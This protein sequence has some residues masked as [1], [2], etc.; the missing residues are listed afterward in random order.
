M[1]AQIATEPFDSPEHAF[2]I[3]WDGVR[4]I[5]LVEPGQLRL[6][7]RRFSEMR[8]QYP[9]LAGLSELPAGTVVDGEII[10]LD[11]GRSSFQKLAQRIHLNDPARIAMASRRLPT[12]FV[13]FDL[14]YSAGVSVMDQSLR[15]RRVLLTAL[16]GE[17]KDPHVVAADFVEG[18]GLAYFEAAK[19]AGLEGI[20]AKRLDS[21]YL[22]G[23]RTSHWTKI[24]VARVDAF[25]I[26]GYVQREG[27]PFVSPLILGLHEGKRWKYKGNVGTGFTEAQ[28]GEW[29][30]KLKPLPALVDPPKDGPKDAAWRTTNLRCRVRF[31]EETADGRLRGPV[32]ESLEG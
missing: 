5:A 31:F 22:P 23:K 1:L 2:E 30:R 15:E 8:E 18:Q 10:V 29:Y 6:Q 13:V 11:S 17:L 4:C 32:F 26:L 9:E 24:K 21:P 20:M 25:D 16:I 12:T 19:Q 14:L 27:Q 7:N 3:K 28:R